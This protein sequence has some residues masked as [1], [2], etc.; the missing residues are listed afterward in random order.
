MLR[1][2]SRWIDRVE[3]DAMKTG[4]RKLV[5]AVQYRVGWRYLLGEA[6]DHAGL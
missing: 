1:W 5:S 4:C 6:K 3:E 2:K